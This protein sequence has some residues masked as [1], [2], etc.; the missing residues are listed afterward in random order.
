VEMGEKG[1]RK[2]GK[3]EILQRKREEMFTWLVSN[4][5]PLEEN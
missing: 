4:A 1:V 5:R 3:I 2:I